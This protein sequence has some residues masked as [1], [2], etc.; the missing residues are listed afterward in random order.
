MN[1]LIKLD[2][3]QAIEALE[4]INKYEAKT[5]HPELYKDYI[6][7]VTK[8]KLCNTCGSSLL[9]AHNDFQRFIFTKI[10]EN[11]D[12]LLPKLTLTSGKYA[13]EYNSNTIP[14][15][16][17]HNLHLLISQMKKEVNNFAKR[18]YNDQA[19]LVLTDHAAISDYIKVRMS[20]I[21]EEPKSIEM[22][23]IVKVIKD[24]K[25]IEDNKP[26]VLQ[27]A[28][29][30]EVVLQEAV[31]EITVDS[32]S[33]AEGKSNTNK[34]PDNTDKV[35]V[36]QEVEPIESI[37]EQPIEEQPSLAIKSKFILTPQRLQIASEM[38]A[39]SI[40]LN[41]IAKQLNV[42]YKGLSAAIKEYEASKVTNSTT[43]KDKDGAIALF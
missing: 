21:S 23:S 35:L 28:V 20:Y 25:V 19:N 15:Y 6:Q 31:E 38:K 39:D 30:Q 3:Q 5:L 22:E 29:L 14:F 9:R 12:Y 17:Y 16:T 27:Q 32:V 36:E 40:H 11:Y 1:N 33:K 37:E 41:A 24:I 34:V 4:H 8:V 2:E 42:E 13:S 43:R 7:S 10:K 18:G 26:V